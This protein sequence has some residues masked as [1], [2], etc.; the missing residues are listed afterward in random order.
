MV[1][2]PPSKAIPLIRPDFSRPEIVII[3]QNMSLNQP[4]ND[5]FKQYSGTPLIRSLPSNDTLL[6]KPDFR[7]P[8]KVKYY[9]Y[10]IFPLQRGHLYYKATFSTQKGHPYKRGGG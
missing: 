7:W 9:M 6:I 4:I 5:I 1:P 3:K 2:P 10:L 8:E